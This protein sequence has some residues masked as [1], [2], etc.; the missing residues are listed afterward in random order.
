L[1]AFFVNKTTS[2]Q[3][4][5]KLVAFFVYDRA[6]DYSIQENSMNLSSKTPKKSP[7]T[8][9]SNV[10]TAPNEE[11]TQR[12]KNTKTEELVTNPKPS[13][14]S[15][16]GAGSARKVTEASSAKARSLPAKAKAAKPKQ[17]TPKWQEPEISDQA[18]MDLPSEKSEVGSKEVVESPISTGPLSA[19]KAEPEIQEM[20]S[21]SVL[22]EIKKV[23]PQPQ[24]KIRPAD[25]SPL[26]MDLKEVKKDD[27]PTLEPLVGTEDSKPLEVK[28]QEEVLQSY[29][30]RE[31]GIH[32]KASFLLRNLN[33][34][35]PADKL[36]DAYKEIFRDGDACVVLKSLDQKYEFLFPVLLNILFQKLEEVTEEDLSPS[37]LVIVSK[38][39]HKDLF[40]EKCDHFSEKLQ[41]LFQEKLD[42]A[43]FLKDPKTSL[44]KI[45]Q[46]E[47]LRDVLGKKETLSGK[48]WNS[49]VFFQFCRIEALKPEGQN[50]KEVFEIDSIQSSPCLLMAEVNSKFVQNFVFMTPRRIWLYD[51]ATDSQTTS[52]IPQL[53]LSV[54]AE[55]KFQVLHGILKSE[56]PFLAVV[57]V[58]TKLVG[59]WLSYK[60]VKN[61]YKVAQLTDELSPPDKAKLL[62]L[63]ENNKVD[64]VVA[65]DKYAKNL[66]LPNV[67]KVFNFDVPEIVDNYFY[68]INRDQG[69]RQAVPKSV[70][71]VCEDYGFHMKEIEASTTQKLNYQTP[72]S[73]LFQFQDLSDSPLDSQGRVKHF[74]STLGGQQPLPLSPTT[75]AFVP[76]VAKSAPGA[77]MGMDPGLNR[78]GSPVIP[79]APIPTLPNS[80]IGGGS[81]GAKPIRKEAFKPVESPLA[82]EAKPKSAFT[83]SMP[84]PLAAETFTKSPF[85]DRP[86]K[87]DHQSTQP[88]E[89]L[90][91]PKTTPAFSKASSSPSGKPSELNGGLKSPRVDEKS[92]EALETLLAGAKA[93]AEL[94]RYSETIPVE[95]SLTRTARIKSIFAEFQDKLVDELEGSVNETVTKFFDLFRSKKKKS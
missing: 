51:V 88:L 20:V 9:K 17:D 71:L 15:A 70:T 85:K 35:K 45:I 55:E 19:A 79:T 8:K 90:H 6:C 38:P 82:P 48:K 37:V 78:I 2:R 10:Q 94:R 77:S 69:F 12:S 59:D 72:D 66:G 43:A 1:F 40:L 28:I 16:V 14:K 47:T 63:I 75:P 44:R 93:A 74:L 49:T 29:Q 24:A 64:V 73:S 21:T 92:K 32:P 50:F 13:S 81:A 42:S 33:T 60:L 53:I 4:F 61:D 67:K 34:P 58:N 46:I 30:F 27:S 23:D 89:S 25:V 5:A 57:F 87:T 62:E 18:P 36:K 83:A 80:V 68:R 7:S 65:T 3:K 26:S 91:T 95:Q 41:T 86:A 76:P 39:Y 56:N 54:S 52:H 22:P 31:L 11:T 84:P